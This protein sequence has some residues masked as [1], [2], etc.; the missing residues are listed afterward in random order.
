MNLYSY[1]I[2]TTNIESGAAIVAL[3]IV[4]G[5]IRSGVPFMLLFGYKG[6]QKQVICD[7]DQ[8]NG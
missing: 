6:T 1:I 4:H 2:Y 3:C 7:T 5:Y 8:T